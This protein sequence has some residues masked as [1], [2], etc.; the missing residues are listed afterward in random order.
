MSDSLKAHGY[1][2]SQAPLSMEIPRQEYWDGL[3]FTPPRDLP[4][5]G[6]KLAFST[7][8]LDSLPLNHMGSPPSLNK[9]ALF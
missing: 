3:S 7:L 4:N 8:Q 1:I 6:I 9:T 5:S 2:A